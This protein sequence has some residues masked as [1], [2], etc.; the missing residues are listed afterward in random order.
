MVYAAG[1]IGLVPSTMTLASEDQQP[2]LSLS[3]VCRVLEAN[4]ANMG[5]ALLGVCYYTT[6][7][8]EW[9]AKQIWRQVCTCNCV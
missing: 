5:S 7:H 6:Q 1:Q 2:S 8:A 4:G 9:I 3:H